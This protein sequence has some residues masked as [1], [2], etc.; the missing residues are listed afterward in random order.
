MVK[1]GGRSVLELVHGHADQLSHLVLDGGGLT[2]RS[3]AAVST[4]PHL[5]HLDISFCDTL[6]D[7]SLQHLQVN[8]LIYEDLNI[9]VILKEIV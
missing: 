8:G 4:C 7:S 5:Q 1:V 6:T 2:D 3:V 9:F